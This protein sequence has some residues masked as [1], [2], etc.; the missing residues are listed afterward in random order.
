[1]TLLR[2]VMRRSKSAGSMVKVSRQIST[3]TG[4]APNCTTTLAVAGKVKSAT[5][6]SSPGPT[7]QAAR[8][9]CSAVVQELVAKA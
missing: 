6:T 9:R 1:M 8:A 3:I 2:G 7:P 4:T 5:K